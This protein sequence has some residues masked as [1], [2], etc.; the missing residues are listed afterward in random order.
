MLG[1]VRAALLGAGA[2]M[3]FEV[4]TGEVTFTTVEQIVTLPTPVDLG[5]S[6][7]LI[8]QYG[9]SS[10]NAANYMIEVT[11]T[12][13]TSL[14][15]RR[16]ASGTSTTIRW[17]VVTLSAGRVRQFESIA[18]G[19]TDTV[20]TPA[21]DSVSKAFTVT[22]SRVNHNVSPS[23]QAGYYPRAHLLDTGTLR[24]VASGND[25]T[26]TTFLVEAP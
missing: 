14:R 21:V 16:Y 12:G 8:Q 17:Y 10:T 7:A 19:T 6:F 4:Q 25:V 15:L 5:K 1:A 23:G 13:S 18:G 20:L 22:T 26:H 9:P 2:G 3:S 11:L 24:V